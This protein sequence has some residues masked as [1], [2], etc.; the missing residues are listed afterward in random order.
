MN[1]IKK[2][3]QSVR[4]KM[5]SGDVIAFK[6]RN[7]KDNDK[8]RQYHQNVDHIGIICHM[9]LTDDS[10]GRFYNHVVELINRP[11]NNQF[12]FSFI[13]ERIENFNGT[14][15]WLP[16]NSDLRKS[17]FDIIR[18]FNQLFYIAPR[19]KSKRS[20]KINFFDQNSNHKSLVERD[21]ILTAIDSKFSSDTSL[22][23]IKGLS[24]SLMPVISTPPAR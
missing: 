4:Q 10:T 15:W 3:Y 14:I 20:N 17:K 18:F 8:N 6:Y 21:L 1:M 19:R 23:L 5:K 22:Q 13:R 9:Q 24:E 11:K 12:T 16:L 2:D 7:N